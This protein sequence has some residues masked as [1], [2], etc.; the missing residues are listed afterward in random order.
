MP[1]VPSRRRL[2][3]PTYLNGYPMKSPLHVFPLALAAAASATL[4]WAVYE[5]DNHSAAA[6]PA[7][8]S[9]AADSFVSTLDDSQKQRVV[10][11]YD[12]QQRTTWHFIPMDTRDGV[13]LMEMSQPQQKAAYNLLQAALSEVGYE[14]SRTIM[15]LESLLRRLEGAGSEQKRN[16]DKYYFEIFGEPTGSQPWQLSVEGHHLSLNFVIQQ[17]RV[18]E[19]TPQFMGSN[20]ATLK[21][22]YGDKWTQGMSVLSAEESLGFTLVNALD[23]QQK[24]T[25]IVSDKA[26]DEIHDAGAVHTSIEDTVGIA[27]SELNDQQRDT[28]KQLLVTYTDNMRPEVSAARWSAIDKSGFDKVHFAWYGATKPGIGHAYRIQ[29]PTFIVEFVNNQADAEGNPANHVHCVWRDTDGDF[30]L[31]RE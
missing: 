13:P 23:D 9:A 29:G 25:G 18:I 5:L 2:A 21:A 24:K 27:A 31:E 17:D 3:I 7:K 22:D 20:P 8:L 16:P 6:A 26:L 10:R 19:A 28:L 15:H 11:P 30:N 12:N 1:L 14:K 4:G